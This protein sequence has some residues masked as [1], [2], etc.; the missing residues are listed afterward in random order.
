[1][2]NALLLGSTG[3]VGLVLNPSSLF[4]GREIPGE[5]P[6]LSETQFSPL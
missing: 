2:K 6:S 1:M 4:T 3:R 5:L